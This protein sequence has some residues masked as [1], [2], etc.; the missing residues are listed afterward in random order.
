MT[1]HKDLYQLAQGRQKLASISDA[2]QTP[3][4]ADNQRRVTTPDRP[5]EGTPDWLLGR[6]MVDHEHLKR[7]IREEM[8]ELRAGLV[9]IQIDQHA[10]QI[11]TVK[12]SE[13]VQLI[14]AL[15]PT[16]REKKLLAGFIAIIMAIL[17]SKFGID[18]GIIGALK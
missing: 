13:D 14:L 2:D 10:G 17:A 16:L 4:S 11:A 1:A 7:T 8:D 15:V 18:I 6:L 3:K 5:E 12:M 9:R